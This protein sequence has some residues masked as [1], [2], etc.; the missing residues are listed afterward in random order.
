MPK[1]GDTAKEFIDFI[2]PICLRNEGNALPYIARP[3]SQSGP[4]CGTYCLKFAIDCLTAEKNIYTARKRDGAV[5]TQSL[6]ALLKAQGALNIQPPTDGPDVVGVGGIFR[7]QTFA[8]AANRALGLN[9]QVVSF[10]DSVTLY[11][12]V[13]QAIDSNEPV[14]F[15][16]NP[17]DATS[18]PKATGNGENAH[19]CTIIAY[20]SANSKDYFAIMDPSPGHF[21]FAEADLF[22]LSNFLLGNLSSG[23]Y[24]KV[25]TENYGKPSDQHWDWMSRGEVHNQVFLCS[26]ANMKEGKKSGERYEIKMRNYKDKPDGRR[27]FE[28]PAVDLRIDLKGKMV[29]VRT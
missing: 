14:I 1:I 11:N 22:F 21:W 24:Y 26:S 23:T 18:D 4:N 2:D 8:D 6:R 28:H 20:F 17:A 9:A 13:K 15:P 7:A 25:K 16:Y 29:V 12:A 10:S 19:W 27:L 3:A 5:G